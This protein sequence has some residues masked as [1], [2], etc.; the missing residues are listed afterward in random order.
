MDTVNLSPVIPTTWDSAPPGVTQL[1]LCVEWTPDVCITGWCT[2]LHREVYLHILNGGNIWV[3]LFDLQACGTPQCTCR[4]SFVPSTVSS[5]FSFSS[6]CAPVPSTDLPC[7]LFTICSLIFLP[8]PY[9]T[10]ISPFA[11]LT[12]VFPPPFPQ[13]QPFFSIH[14]CFC[15][16]HLLVCWASEGHFSVR[17]GGRGWCS[18]MQVLCL[19]TAG[20]RT[21]GRMDDNGVKWKQSGE[22]RRKGGWGGWRR[23][24]LWPLSVT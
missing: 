12:P 5:I 6:H 9:T 14:F 20:E 8:S 15:F 18:Y 16:Y 23:N 7:F 13:P 10:I 4:N 21:N 11:F 24:F 19:V 3:I 2:R 1:S 22:K 17:D